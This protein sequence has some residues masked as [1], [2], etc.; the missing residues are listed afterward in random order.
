MA[1]DDEPVLGVQVAGWPA[2][3]VD[4]LLRRHGAPYLK[5]MSGE[6]RREVE[7]FRRAVHAAALYWQARASVTEV[8]KRSEPETAT[9]SQSDEMSTAEAATYLGVSER[10]VCQLASTWQYDGLA[11][12]A[13]RTWLLDREAVRIYRGAA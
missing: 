1:E 12:K 10:R 9:R 5:A 3:V 6:Q 11:R 13:G 4:V 8:P 7:T 2:V